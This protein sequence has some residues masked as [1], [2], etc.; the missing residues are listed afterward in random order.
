MS[1]G[2]RKSGREVGWGGIMWLE[3]ILHVDMDSFFVEVERRRDPALR[4]RAVAVGGTGPRGVIA[5]ASYEARAFGVSSAQPTSI[6]R[7]KCP[8]LVV[9]PSDHIA[10]REASIEVFEIFR[11][12]TPLV[13][14]LSLDEAFLDVSG[15]KRHYESSWHVASAIKGEIAGNLGLPA[16]VGVA[17]VKFIAKLA[18]GR[19]KPDGIHLVESS[20]QLE[21]LH[22]LPVTAMWGVGPSTQA[23]L[24][25][26]G[27]ETIGDLAAVPHESLVASL[28]PSLGRHLRDLSNGVDPRRVEADSESKS[29]SVEE[30][31]DDDLAGADVLETALLAHAQRLSFRLRRAGLRGSTLSL[32]VRFPDFATITRSQTARRP[33]DSGRDIYSMAKNLISSADVSSPVRLLGLAMTALIPRDRPEQGALDDEGSWGKVE[34]SLI[35]VQDKFGEGA[36]KPARLAGSEGR[37]ESRENPDA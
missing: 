15:L 4:D 2:R 35:A 28:G 33:I 27:V 32:K 21:F 17:A 7:R 22:V 3:P 16:S 11:S 20:S 31:Y 24:E 5:S 14:G 19:A 37:A 36:V 6:A 13:E 9:V 29:I 8:E 30:T 25:R 10:Y 1:S 23:A 26:F 34:E 12:F 18:S